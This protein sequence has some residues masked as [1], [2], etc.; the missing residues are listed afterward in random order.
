MVLAPGDIYIGSKALHFNQ[1][2]NNQDLCSNEVSFLQLILIPGDY[3][4]PV[5]LLFPEY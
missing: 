5:L 3:F 1:W 4:S 2:N